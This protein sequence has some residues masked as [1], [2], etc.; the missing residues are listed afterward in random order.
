MKENRDVT[1]MLRL[2]LATSGIKG[3]AKFQSLQIEQL[4]SSLFT[5]TLLV[6]N[7]TNTK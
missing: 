4:A 5:L 1:K 7:L 6:A 3:L 2:F